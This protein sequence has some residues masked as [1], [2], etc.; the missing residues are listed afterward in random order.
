MSPKD[1]GAG[2]QG[3]LGAATFEV[4]RPFRPFSMFACI[5]PAQ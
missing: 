5:M 4:A 3:A 2:I 1:C